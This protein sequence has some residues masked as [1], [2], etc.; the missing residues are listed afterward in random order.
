MPPP[1]GAKYAAPPPANNGQPGRKGRQPPRD[2]QANDAQDAQDLT[3][4][5][6]AAVRG[7]R[8]ANNETWE[9]AMN[10]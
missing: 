3:F 9:E 7:W 2:H 10:R 6:R 1:V 5:Q 8:G 4:A